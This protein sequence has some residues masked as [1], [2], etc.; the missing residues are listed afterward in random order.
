M[1]VLNRVFAT[2]DL[3]PASKWRYV[4][5]DVNPAD[6][7]SRGVFPQELTEKELWW[8]GPPWLSESSVSWPIR[9]DIGDPPIDEDT[10]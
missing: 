4:A 1:F 10:P 5:T 9:T 8:K 6:L 2:T 7:A 3:L